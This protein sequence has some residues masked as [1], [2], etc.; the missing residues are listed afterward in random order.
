MKQPIKESEH[1]GDK[2]TIEDFSKVLKEADEIVA[3]NG[4]NFD[5]K[6]IRGRGIKSG[7]DL[8]E[9]I[10]THDTLKIARQKF[11]FN[12]NKL[13]YLA[14]YLGVGGKI[15]TNYSL[16][17]E[18]ILDKNQKSLKK[19]IKYCN[20]DVAILEQVWY[21]LKPY[22]SHKTSVT[23]DRKKCPECG[24]STEVSKLRTRASGVKVVQLQC[25]DCGKYNTIPASILTNK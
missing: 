7:I 12:S 6:W 11:R 4:D 14:K 17:K 8:S 1:C 23:T 22:A 18:I 2:I 5:L 19:M 15:E 20:N 21:K 3:H 16:W 24:G 10:I 25:K 9:T 13:D